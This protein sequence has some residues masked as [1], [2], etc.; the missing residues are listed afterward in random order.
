MATIDPHL[1]SYL[2]RY[3]R[4]FTTEEDGPENHGRPLIRMS[5]T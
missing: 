1:A 3:Y 2:L 4:Q 5:C